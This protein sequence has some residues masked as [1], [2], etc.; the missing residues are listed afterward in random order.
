LGLL[1]DTKLH[2]NCF[3][4][5]APVLVCG[6]FFQMHNLQF[7]MHNDGCACGALIMSSEEL[8]QVAIERLQLGMT[9]RVTAAA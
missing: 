8:Y 6:Q 5:I 1:S 2:S 9:R 3:I 4:T 7:T